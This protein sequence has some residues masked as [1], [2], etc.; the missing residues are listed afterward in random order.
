MMMS[1]KGT[2]EIT[3]MRITENKE[4][5]TTPYLPQT[6]DPLEATDIHSI[7]HSLTPEKSLTSTRT[8]IGLLAA[9][10]TLHNPVPFAHPYLLL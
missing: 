8:T 10:N 5:D 4:N 1:L 9:P 3:S 7:S 6:M 2:P